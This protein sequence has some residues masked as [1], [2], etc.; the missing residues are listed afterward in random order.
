MSGFGLIMIQLPCEQPVHA[1]SSVSFQKD[2]VGSQSLE[3]I[4]L[5]ISACPCEL[6]LK[7]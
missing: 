6:L 5:I 4:D 2:R 7:V 1:P 3:G